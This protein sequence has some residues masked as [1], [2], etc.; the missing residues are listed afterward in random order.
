MKERLALT[1]AWL[2]FINA[3]FMLFGFALDYL[4]ELLPA[5]RPIRDGEVMNNLIF[6]YTR[7]AYLF[8]FVLAVGG[9]LRCYC[10]HP[11]SGLACGLLRASPD[12]CLGRGKKSQ[13]NMP[14]KCQ[15][16]SKF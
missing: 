2:A 6:Y 14:K 1:L 7:P 12:S 13:A 11:L 3:A 9:Q 5:L 10:G 16:R 15:P 8:N 4:V